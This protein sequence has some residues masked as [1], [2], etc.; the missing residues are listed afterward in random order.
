MN[1]QSMSM[2]SSECCFSA[3]CQDKAVRAGTG[4]SDG[5][6]AASCQSKTH[7]SHGE[8]RG[9]GKRGQAEQGTECNLIL[10]SIKTIIHNE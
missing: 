10:R 7:T 3:E 1:H 8:E 5:G 9:R 6:Q 4:G 2:F